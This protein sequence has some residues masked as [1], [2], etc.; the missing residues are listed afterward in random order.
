MPSCHLVIL[1]NSSEQLN[2]IGVG[3]GVDQEGGGA[4]EVLAQGAAGRLDKASLVDRGQHVAGPR[5]ALGLADGEGRV[6]H[7]QPWV[8]A[9]LIVA[10]RPAEVLGDEQELALFAW[11]QV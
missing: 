1:S 9:L 5:I 6:P 2:R 10:R 7:A 8:A 11:L 3:A 4:L